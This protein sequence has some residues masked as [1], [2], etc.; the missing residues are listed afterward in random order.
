MI[1]L[2]APV[3]YFAAIYQHGEVWA[4]YSVGYFGANN[5]NLSMI[6]FFSCYVLTNFFGIIILAIFVHPIWVII[7]GI[8]I[9]IYQAVFLVLAVK[10][11][12]LVKQ[13]SKCKR[14]EIAKIAKRN[15]CKCYCCHF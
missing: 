2:L 5:L 10:F 7:P 12:L 11:I 13:I 1:H 14:L 8:V 6:V 3:I 15:N 4:M 9:E